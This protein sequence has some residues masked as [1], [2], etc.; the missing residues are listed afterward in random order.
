MTLTVKV[1]VTIT[2]IIITIKCRARYRTP[3]TTNTEL[4]VTLHNGRKPLSNI[5]KSFPTDA[6]KALYTP[7]KRLHHHLT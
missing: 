6:L 1:I 3:T 5:K 4:H 7:L 2:I